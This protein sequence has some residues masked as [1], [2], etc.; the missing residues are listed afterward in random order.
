[1]FP[2]SP[3]RKAI[4]ANIEYEIVLRGEFQLQNSALALAGIILLNL[5]ITDEVIKRGMLNARWPGRLQWINWG[6]VNLLIDGAHNKAGALQLRNF[7]DKILSQTPQPI[8]WIIGVTQGKDLSAI[9]KTLIRKN[10][11][12]VCVPFTTP[13]GMKWINCWKTKQLKEKNIRTYS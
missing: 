1:L 11:H 5:K 9:L 4:Y 6:S 3:L 10:D 8:S 13:E 12:V 7:V 2:D